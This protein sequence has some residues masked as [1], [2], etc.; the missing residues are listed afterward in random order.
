MSTETGTDGYWAGTRWN[1]PHEQGGKIEIVDDPLLG[2]AFR[3]VATTE[4]VSV[5]DKLHRVYMDIFGSRITGRCSIKVS[6]VFSDDYYGHDWDHF[7]NLLG[8]FDATPQTSI[9]ARLGYSILTSVNLHFD[10]KLI[11]YAPPPYSGHSDIYYQG[12]TVLLPNTRYDLEVQFDGQDSIVVFL[13]DKVEVAGKL[14]PR[15]LK[16]E[17][18]G[19]LGIVGGHAGLYRNGAKV[20]QYILNGPL[21]FT[22]W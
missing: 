10:R 6:F 19:L 17:N 1:N 5:A 20:G 7:V 11:V 21:E 16:P 3:L 9:D 2:R 12:T 22:C 8:V 15:S 14:D 4:E 18:R 13:N